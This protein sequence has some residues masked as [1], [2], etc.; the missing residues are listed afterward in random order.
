M[1]HQQHGFRRG[2][3]SHEAHELAFGAELGPL[4]QGAILE[5]SW[6]LVSTCNWAYN[7]G[8]LIIARVTSSGT[9]S[10]KIP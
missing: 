2:E 9:S 8:E 10:D 7:P 1:S 4:R 5:G 3:N 6:G